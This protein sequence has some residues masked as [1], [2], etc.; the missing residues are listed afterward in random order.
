MD[1][2][3]GDAPSMASGARQTARTE[4]RI[5]AFR[6]LIDRI[7][8]WL[9]AERDQL[10]LWLPVAFGAGIALW[11]V[12][13]NRTGWITLLIL[14]AALGATGVAIGR[15]R[16]TG[17]AMLM[18]ALALTAGCALI[19]SKAHWVSAAILERPV[20]V[21]FTADVE[22]VQRLPARE[23]VRVVLRPA[24]E[25]GLPSRIRVNIADED[26]PDGLGVGDQLTMRARLMPPPHAALPGAYDF[27]RV[28]W[29]QG[30]GATGRALGQVERTGET[31][32]TGPGLR[33]RM[34]AHIQSR[35][36]AGAGGI[37]TAL[38]TGD[39]GAMPE[40]DAEA[41][42]RSGLAHL[43]SVSGLH[44][45]AVVGATM[46][47]VLRL[48]ALS[49]ALALRWPLLLIAAGAGAVAGIGY[50]FVT[51]AEVPTVRSCIAALLVLGGLALGRDAITLRL[52]ATGALV[53]LL[54]WP[55]SLI[56]AS[57]QLSFAAVTAIIALHDHPSV[58]RLL[59]RHDEGFP[60]RMG[61][62]LL[63]LL[64]TGLAVEIALS[65]IA[66]FHFHKA[67]LYG[68]LANIVAIPLTTFVV[69]P[70]E[71]IAL[72]FDLIE[73]GAPFWWMAG[74][75]LNILLAIAHAAADAPGSV[76][77]LAS[78]PKGAFALMI[79]GG[80]W[81]CLWR[82]KFR[83]LGLVPIAAGALWALSVSPPDILITGDGRHLAI[84][85]VQGRTALLRPRAGD[86][87]RDLL[88]E[89]SGIDGELADLDSL[90]GARCGPDMCAVDLERNG[91]HWRLIA[92]RSGYL[93]P[94][95]D[96]V[97]ACR[98][99]DIVVSDRRLPR[100]CTPRWLKADRPL[101]M[102]SGGLA[103]HLS[104]PRAVTVVTPGSD[105]PWVHPPTTMPVN[106]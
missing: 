68:A 32:R 7:E 76:A 79:A 70:L 86:F 89:S 50:T 73:L 4:A 83:H 27:A 8:T 52:V 38:A 98:E 102:Q 37:A 59:S 30:I 49:P 95:S 85:D 62:G 104:P 55:E 47:V 97:R 100:T 65:P 19:W 56:G 96:F 44:I 46:L 71:T 88:A 22:T 80:L 28:A 92:T 78:M 74:Q 72:L 12:I 16:R 10:P 15:G 6:T 103:I 42:R 17:Q 51:G 18:V 63:G 99:A 11:F 81:L 43:L 84:R 21:R 41:M 69:M 35:L 26:V 48:L 87:V 61:R 29:F 90:D 36:E 64:I 105:H 5:G 67:G 93:L 82:T 14:A 33:E 77:T 106:Q 39:Q 40:E 54:F 34:S 45:T 58:R 2:M 75:A 66:L 1:N 53:V 101:L 9:E 25:S 31:E 3:I 13:P 91:R 24:Q 23:M 60:E 57:F 20:V 94:I